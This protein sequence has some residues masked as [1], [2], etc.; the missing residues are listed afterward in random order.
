MFVRSAA[1]RHPVRSLTNT[2]FEGGQPSTQGPAG[3]RSKDKRSDG[4]VLTL[5]LVLDG[6]GFVRRS[7]VFA[8]NR[9]DE[10]RT[11]AGMLEALEAPRGALVVMDRG[12]ATEDRIQ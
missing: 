8:W 3:S 12:V 1:D 4:P 6:A 2:F 9:V 7:K 5:G 11:L 10:H